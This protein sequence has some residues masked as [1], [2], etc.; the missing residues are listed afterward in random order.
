[1]MQF[2]VTL[3]GYNGETDATDHLV[4]W[5]KTLNRKILERWI[6]LVGL[7]PY[8]QSIDVVH[9]GQDLEFIDGIDVLLEPLWSTE[10]L[11]VIRRPGEK[12]RVWSV[13]VGKNPLLWQ[14]TA[15]PFDIST[16]FAESKACE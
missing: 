16:W 4:K 1:M 2:D 6:D 3:N 5:V 8:V 12:S 10:S 7:R 14:I 15:K 9:E 11:R 13:Q